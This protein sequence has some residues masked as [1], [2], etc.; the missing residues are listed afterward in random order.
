MKRI[1]VLARMVGAALGLALAPCAARAGSSTD[2]IL[3]WMVFDDYGRRVVPDTSPTDVKYIDELISRPDGYSVNGARLRVAGTDV[4]LNVYLS[5][6]NV[7][8]QNGLLP[9]VPDPQEGYFSKAGPVWTDLGDYASTEYSF[10]VELGHWKGDEWTVMAASMVASY[11]YLREGGWT[12]DTR[13]DPP[14]Q[15]PWTPTYAVPEPTSGLLLLVGGALLALRRRATRS[16]APTKGGWT[17]LGGRTLR[18][19]RRIAA[20]RATRSVAPTGTG[21][22]RADGVGRTLR[23]RRNRAA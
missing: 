19:R 6:E 7:P 8:L 12:T 22:V 14:R 5:D 15:G 3:L 16:V 2:G 20:G 9:I 18:V 10:L 17:G 11:D 21:G 4:Y 13:E 23:V 1:S